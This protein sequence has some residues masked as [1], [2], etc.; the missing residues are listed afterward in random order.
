[1]KSHN[2]FEMYSRDNLSILVTTIT[3]ITARL[4]HVRN[5]GGAE[6]VKGRHP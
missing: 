1:M 6:G 2:V 3:G 5:V 4:S